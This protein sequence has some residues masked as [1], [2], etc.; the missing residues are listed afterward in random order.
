MPNDPGA[1]ATARRLP[2]NVAKKT[3]HYEVVNTRWA[4]ASWNPPGFA[5]E[6]V[7]DG[8]GKAVV[9]KEHWDLFVGE[10]VAFSMG[11]VVSDA[12]GYGP[13]K[14]AKAASK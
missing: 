6:L 7:F 2:P 13:K 12:K 4:N 1:A 8:E 5:Y 3:P 9:P 10:A 14:S 11:F